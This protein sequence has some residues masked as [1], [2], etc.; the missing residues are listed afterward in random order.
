MATVIQADRERAGACARYFEHNFTA[1]EIETGEADN[2]LLVET[3]TKFREAST[4]KLE[5][6]LAVLARSLRAALD[7]Y[8]RNICFHEET[9]RG[10]NIWTICDQ[11]GAKWADDEG[12]FTNFK[13]PQ[14]ISDAFETLTRIQGEYRCGEVGH[15]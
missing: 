6:D 4:E 8:E 10:G 11:C 5:A 12:G 2:C 13:Y 14:E 7:H 3:I 9:Y 1:V 15:G